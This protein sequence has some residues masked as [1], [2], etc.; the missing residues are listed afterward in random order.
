MQTAH[1]RAQ[2]RKR[3]ETDFWRAVNTCLTF[4]V[5]LGAVVTTVLWFLP[6]LRKIDEMK[7]TLAGLQKELAAEQLLLAKQQRQEGWLNES[8]EY[9]ELMARDLLDKVK[10]GETIIRLD[11]AAPSFP[12]PPVAPA[13]K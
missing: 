8:P 9:V 1:A 3:R 5:V 6:E 12:M 13:A 4:L 7:A 10:N 11:E 2:L